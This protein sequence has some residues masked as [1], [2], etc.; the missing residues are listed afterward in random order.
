MGVVIDSNCLIDLERELA[1][2]SLSPEMLPPDP[3]VSFVTI[4]ELWVGTEL[5]D[6]RHR[7]AR[8]RFVLTLME[9]AELVPF[10]AA[11]ARSYGRIAAHLRKTGL[12]IG[13]R[14][15]L[16]A[17]SALANGHSVMTANVGEF[18]RVPGLLVIPPPR[19]S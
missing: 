16:I 15:M 6:A 18:S 12:T 10:A 8:E 13:E 2:G 5:A 4:G 17:A 1:R 9:N 14:D 19:G 7:E 3:V 11:E